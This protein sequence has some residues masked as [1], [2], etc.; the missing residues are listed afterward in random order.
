MKRLMFIFGLCLISQLL[1]A[2][3]HRFFNRIT[4]N[5]GLASNNVYAIWQDKKGYIWVG[6]SNGLQRFDGK[7]FLY[8]GIKKPQEL[9]AKPV[10]QIMEDRE[11]NMWLNYGEEYGIYN[12]ADLSFKSIPYE[13]REDKHRN[14][15]LWIDSKGNVFLILDRHR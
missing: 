4:I 10:R 14:K 12:P 2:N 5:E 9:P 8:F 7:Y 15:K 13:N 1:M 6:S 11:G 3:P